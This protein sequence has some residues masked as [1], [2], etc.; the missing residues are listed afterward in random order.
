MFLAIYLLP[1]WGICRL[2]TKIQNKK[3]APAL[4]LPKGFESTHC[5]YCEYHHS[6]FYSQCVRNPQTRG[7]R[8]L[9]TLSPLHLRYTYEVP[10]I[11]KDRPAL[12]LWNSYSVNSPH[13]AK[14]LTRAA[15][16]KK[17]H[18]E[19]ELIL[20]HILR[21]IDFRHTDAG[22]QETVIMRQLRNQFC[23]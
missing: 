16:I 17:P 18:K 5:F 22:K 2:I 4:D 19:T 15:S 23:S 10:L 21:C 13:P 1:F 20:Y 9:F 12:K 3:S 6:T 11:L 7:L 8:P 14:L